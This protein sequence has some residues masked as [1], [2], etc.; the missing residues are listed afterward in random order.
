M[1]RRLLIISYLFPPMGGIAVQR[2]LS[3]AKYLPE[4]GFDVHVLRAANA[5]APV[6][7][8][9]LLRHLPPQITVHTALT[10]E[11]PFALRHRLWSLLGSKKEKVKPT[12]R[13]PT[14]WRALK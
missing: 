9:G 3:L 8:P 6:Y 7:D 10:L 13:S 5:A 2:A 1:K 12:N 14:P 4:C 11:L